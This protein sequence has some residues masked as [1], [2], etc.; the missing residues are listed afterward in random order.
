M[1]QPFAEEVPIYRFTGG[2][3]SAV[4]EPLNAIFNCSRSASPL[5]PVLIHSLFQQF[6]CSLSQ[7]N[8]KNAYVL[9]EI[10]NAMMQK[11]IQS[12]P[13]FTAITAVSCPWI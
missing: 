6:L 8:D 13:T 10:G 5:N 11:S 3:R 1:L 12:P 2:P 4:F 9:E 7:Q